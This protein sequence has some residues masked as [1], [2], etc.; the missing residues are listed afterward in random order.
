M[1]INEKH[2]ERIKIIYKNAEEFLCEITPS[3][4]RGEELEKYF[5]PVKKSKSKNEI[6]FHLFG[7]LQN[8]QMSTNVIG[9]WKDDK[10][11]IFKDI[12][13]DYDADTILSTYTADTLYD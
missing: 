1:N 2:V 13:F 4:L 10:K 7:S 9:F 12:L 6:L 5:N 8:K 11:Q 3:E